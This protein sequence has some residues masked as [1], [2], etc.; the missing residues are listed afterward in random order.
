MPV[1]FF[2]HGQT[3][4]STWLR[5]DKDK[6]LCME[7]QLPLHLGCIMCTLGLSTVHK[8]HALRLSAGYTAAD[9]NLTEECLMDAGFCIDA[10]C[11]MHAT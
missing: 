7:V 2:Y 1:T 8:W 5:A 4:R 10:Q 3:G 6:Q 11:A 9:A